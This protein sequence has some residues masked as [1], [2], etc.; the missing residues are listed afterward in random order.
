MLSPNIE[1]IQMQTYK[2][3]MKCPYHSCQVGFLLT[4]AKYM[5]Y[6]HKFYHRTLTV[7]PVNIFAMTFT[8]YIYLNQHRPSITTYF[9]FA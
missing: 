2:L 6:F 5:G 1:T 3:N 4:S 9:D 8:E 7:A